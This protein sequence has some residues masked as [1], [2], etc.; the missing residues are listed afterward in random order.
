MTRMTNAHV[1]LLPESSRASQVTL[2]SPTGKF[3]PEVG[4]QVTVSELS[5]A[6]LAA[7][8]AK[9]AAALPPPRGNSAALMLGGHVIWGGFVSTKVTVA[10][11]LVIEPSELETTTM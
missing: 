1:L 10:T 11:S 3:D 7:G 6:S 2:V 5:H 4:T 8:V 9:V